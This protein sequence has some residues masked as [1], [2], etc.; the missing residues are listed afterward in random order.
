MPYNKPGVT[1]VNDLVVACLA[2][3]ENS[4]LPAELRGYAVDALNAAREANRR[5][6]RAV[7]DLWRPSSVPGVYEAIN[8]D[9][10]DAEPK[11]AQLAV[12]EFAEIVQE[13]KIARERVL[14]IYFLISAERSPA[15]GGKEN[16]L[17][18]TQERL[19]RGDFRLNVEGNPEWKL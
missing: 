16:P 9:G 13:L 11:I 5:R 7:H 10:G 6:N 17:R 1:G 19:I 18:E 2:A 12:S 4:P 8:F 15:L 14:P 3:L